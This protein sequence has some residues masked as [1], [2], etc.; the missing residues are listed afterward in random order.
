M[1]KRTDIKKIL[2]IGSGPIVIGQ[3]AEFDYAGTQACL[4]LREEGYEVILCNSN[5][6]T[7]MT[8]TTVADKVYMEPLTLEYIAKILRHE[9]PDAIVP[10][11]GGQTGLNLAMQLEKKGV[12]RECGVELLG[13]SSESIERAEDRELFKELCQSIGEPT[14]PSEITYSLDEAKAAAARIGYPVV[15]RP[16][17]TLGGT[18]G[19]FAYNEEELIEVGLNAFKLSPVHQ[20]LI[21]KS[22]KGYK[23]IEFE[24]MRDSND[25]AITICGME[26]IDPVGV[27]TGDSLV[28]APIMTLNDHDLKMLNESA[29]KIIR[30]LKIEGGCNVQFAL[31]PNSSEYYLIEVNPR[32]SRSSALASKASGYPIARVTAKIAVGMALEDIA[33]ANT[34]AAF[35]PSL[36]YVIAKLPRFPFDKFATAPNTLGTQMK[37]TGEIMGIGSSL[38][39]C[40]LKGVRSLET[41][42]DHFYLPKFDGK[43]KDELIDYIREFRDDNIFAVAALFRLGVSVD[44][45]F[46][47]TQI[48]PYFLD[49]IKEIVDEEKNIANNKGNVEV[50]RN[51]KKMGYSDKFIARL[52]NMP[53]V[54][55]F[56]LRKKENMFPV[57]RMVDTCHTG[58]YIPYF[59][60]S[61]TGENTSVLTDRKK[62]VVLGAGPIRIGQ[63]VE[64]DYSTVHAVTTI[65]NSGYEAIII[66]NN[67]E[68][69][70]T[71]YTTADKLYF[72]PLTTEDVMNIIEFEKPEGVI[73][74]LGGQ[75][76]INLAEPL[77]ARGVKIIGTD[78]DAIERAENRDSFEKILR[79]LGIPQPKGHAVT[80][81]ED[82][83]AAAA[84]IGYPVLVR[85]S[86]V[87]GGRA[88][89]IVSNEEQLRHYLKTAVEIDEDK[90]VLVDKYIQGK[91]VE[92]DAIC[93][94]RDVFVPGIMELV[95]RTGVHSG[96][97]ISVYPTFSISNKVKGIIL[98]Y[99]KK[100]GLGIGIVGLYNIQFIVDKEDNVFIIEVNPRS[101][102]TVPF[103]SKA[104][105]YSLADIAT[106][107]I[108]G[109]SLKEQGIFD[110][111]PDEKKRWYVKVP[112]F[113]FAKIRGLDAYLSP[114]MKSTGEAI[115]YDDKMNRAMYKAL[116]ASGM[117]LQNYGTV[118]ATI[119]D[120]DKD[121]AL[122]LI[123][124][125]YNLGFN[126]QA[127]AGT[128]AFLKENGIRTHVLKKISEGS[129]EIPN[130]IRQGHIAYVINTRNIGSNAMK[131]GHEIRTLATDNNVSIFTNLDTV[132]VLLDVLEETTLTISTIDA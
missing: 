126:I 113:S 3:A 19:G 34:N 95:E 8:D 123:R 110:I 61:Y 121:E 85:P 94:G 124:R 119:A 65:K 55:V 120:E 104:T 18:G 93:D 92:I 112:V 108:L 44:E 78:C 125:F 21:E 97:S 77:R 118:L 70:S 28:V 10:G 38:S 62:I 79:E 84:E 46:K 23:E 127:T 88:M 117:T 37:A 20:V 58:A 72:E 1:A 82:G 98:Q 54:E 50:L 57:Y 39:E 130:A 15:L 83:I 89:Q 16:A 4:A 132:R 128:A 40:L 100:L 102:R 11:I 51:A 105:G 80:K 75:T 42:A 33:I 26:N 122:P 101:S 96:D 32:V 13:T 87:L 74:S 47:I 35:E 131:D 111:Y 52:W 64:F 76:A 45:I 22:V 90:P 30:E 109:K 53:E 43:S 115:G 68:T 6:A 27:H 2:I 12:L 60:S 17:F 25:H 36:D 63:G 103:L 116:Q 48:T 41:G 66:N 59:Y 106:E 129:E 49:C 31:N 56:N 73:A 5:P 69:V 71:D 86:F 9:R 91:E 107:V 99:A 14:I 29:I 7:I 67:P 114:E 24:V 81:I